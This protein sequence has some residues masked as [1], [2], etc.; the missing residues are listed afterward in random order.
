MIEFVYEA[1]RANRGNVITQELIDGICLRLSRVSKP[2][3]DASHWRNCPSET[4]QGYV[5]A[6][7]SIADI[8]PELRH[9]HLA[10]WEE[11]KGPETYGPLNPDYQGYI[12]QERAGQYIQLTL[13]KAGLLVGHF[14]GYL[15]TSRHTQA[16]CAQEDT[17][18]IAK[19]HRKGLL[20]THFLHYAERIAARIGAREFH[21]SVKHANQAAA[22]VL[23]FAGY[24]SVGTEFVKLI[25]EHHVRT[26]TP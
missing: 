23:E 15:F 14:G 21:A 10:H 20:A 11:I 4:Y 12:A 13:R 6:A 17:Y 7:E 2:A 9:L 8:L 18:F 19:E 25:G 24:T 22:K 16:L 26:E 5:F 1:L 3:P